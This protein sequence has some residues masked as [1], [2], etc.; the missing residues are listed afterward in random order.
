[1]VLPSNTYDDCASARRTVNRLF[2]HK[3]ILV[4]K[5]IIVLINMVLN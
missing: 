5:T 4:F 3:S 1:M 2:L